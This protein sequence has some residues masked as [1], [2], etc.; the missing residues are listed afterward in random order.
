M[1]RLN[2][3]LKELNVGINM[4]AEFLQK[5][6]KPLEDASINAKITDEQYDMLLKEFGSDKQKKQE[7]SLDIQ[8]RK[9]KEQAE[10][11]VRKAKEL[12]ELLRREAELRKQKEQQEVFRLESG[13]KSEVKVL[14]KH[15]ETEEMSQAPKCKP[16]KNKTMLEETEDGVY[17]VVTPEAGLNFKK[18]GSIDIN[19][20][21]PSTR[22]QKKTKED[23]RKDSDDKKYI[24]D[25]KPTV[26]RN[27]SSSIK[28]TNISSL[29][30]FDWEQFEA[31]ASDA[32]ENSSSAVS[33]QKHDIVIATVTALNRNEIAVNFGY[34]SDAIIP[35]SE[36]RYNPNLKVGDQID[37]YIEEIANNRGQLLVS[38]RKAR[39]SKAWDKI[40]EAYRNNETIKVYVK[41]ITKGGMI[42][43]ALGIDA[44]MP[45]SQIDI[46]KVFNYDSYIGKTLD[47]KVIKINIENGN[48]VVSHKEIVAEN[49]QK[50]ST[51]KTLLKDIWQKHTEVQEQ[52]LR[53]R[54]EPISIIPSFSTIINEKLHVRIDTSDNTDYL[55]SMIIKSLEISD[56]DCHFDDGYVFAPY[57]NWN[58]LDER[59][60]SRISTQANKEYVSFS[61]CPVIDGKITDIK[62]QFTGV[63]ELLD[64]LEIEYDFD[65]KR[66]LQISINELQRLRNN[67][68][69]QN[70]QVSLPDEASAIIQTYPSILYYLERECPNHKFK[71]VEVFKDSSST[72]GGVIINKQ[73]IVEGGYFNEETLKKL[74]ELFEIRMCKIE[75]EFKIKDSAKGQY[76]WK[77]NRSGLPILEEGTILFRKNVKLSVSDVFDEDKIEV[78]EE[79]LED[80]TDIHFEYTLDCQ[81]VNRIFGKGNYEVIQRFFYKYKENR[82]WATTE[83]L[84]R[85]NDQIHTELKG[86]V[87]IEKNGSSIGIDFNW[88]EKSLPEIL[89]QLSS[90]Y[91]F[92]D[93][94]LFKKGHK[95]NFDIKYKKAELTNL[96]EELHDSFDKLNVELVKKDTELLFY[97]EFDTLEELIAFR[98]QLQ[99]K[100][101]TFDA[102][103][104][105]CVVNDTPAGY[106]KLLYYYDKKSRDEE[107]VDSIRE[108]KGA[109]FSIGDLSIGRLIR[110]SNYPEIVI[111][112]SGDNYEVTKQLIE[113]SEVSSIT[114]DLS[115]DLEKLARLKESL[116]RIVQG[117]DVENASLGDF[118]FDASKAG[119]I[120]DY[121]ESIKLE[122]QEISKHILNKKIDKN[123]PQ[124]IAIAKALLAPDL[125]LIQGPP[126]TGKSTAIAELI[127]QHT[128]ENPDKRILLTSETNLAVDNA[129]DRVVNQ[130]HNLIK[131]IRIG[132]ESRLETEGLQFSYSAMY[133]WA[134]G[135]DWNIKKKNVLID[136]DEDD[137][138]YTDMDS[139]YEAPE[140]L[141]LLNWMENV[142]RRLDSERM[143]SEAQELWI[144]LLEN[145]TPELKNLFF[146]N[147]I[148]NCNVIGATCSS[149]GQKNIIMTESIEN[150]GKRNR[151]VPT[152]FYRIYRQIFSDKEG[153]FNP[154]IYFDMVI[155]DESSKATPAELS[156]PLIYGKKNVIIGDHKQLP[157]MLSRESFINSFDYLIKREKNDD[158]RQK[159]KELKSY[160]LKNFKTLE[161]S[162]F[163]RLFTQIDDNLKGVFNYQFRMHPAIN[164]V[165][166][167]FYKDEG[168]L[169]CGLIT[170]I[171]LGVDD[172][173]YL[174]NGSSRYHGITAGP[175]D[176][177][178][179]VLWIDSSSPEM[180]DGTSR[181]NY[182]E[183]AI[184]KKLLTELNESESFHKY[185]DSWESVED[186]QIGLI[187]FYGKQLR[188]LKDMTREFDNT[189]IPVRVSTVDRFQG[190]ERNII[191]VSMVRSHCIQNEKNQNPNFERYP[192]DGFPKQEDLGFAQSPNRLNVAL[193]RAK[194]LLIIVGNSKLFR[195]KDIYENVY[196]TIADKYNKYG[197]IITASEYGL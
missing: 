185:I 51:D 129:I 145:P 192:E 172:P 17:H 197:K 48:V 159:M 61:Y 113:E 70:L 134:K 89:T 160:V 35:A 130:Y 39:L 34:K 117:R 11:A 191:I 73:L 184:I 108:L 92:I 72:L 9:E 104:Y 19:E 118:I 120:K 119:G 90:E 100:L 26:S 85:F 46:V 68:D 102:T 128:R 96:M 186:K 196:Q 8:K 99:N 77:K 20:I 24:P 107:R 155:Q 135:E 55:K 69:F 152:K 114:P 91:G 167:Q 151:F 29:D 41:C 10:R 147:Y 64:K 3:A 154:K 110:I 66:R 125:A 74:E 148:K 67:E 37:V 23:R 95:C 15:D 4:V 63:K 111:D 44:F 109:D 83:E 22:P 162:H 98:P 194:R 164:D 169:E 168:G 144:N 103:R 133:R 81:I 149:I 18:V 189:Q 122:E 97:R 157:P 60:K 58:N 71:N 163:E 170:P 146:D 28:T 115:G 30:D 79:I 82:S 49:L 56:Q 87:G 38:H 131:P 171:D 93:F 62:A 137:D 123:Q 47:V 181:V 132:D 161:I 136:E 142:G 165:I 76:D 80:T 94:G 59:E 42:V 86:K 193:S 187:S 65:K 21:N 174:N 40:N 84:D 124:K 183:V 75:Y 175:I 176:P 52:I 156:L 16:S 53:Q 116:N 2:K 12:Q 138:V 177:E 57:K 88:K 126:G 105:K 173:D 6:G 78:V 121:E 190:M 33:L 182:G 45:G 13:R 36:L 141:I 179:H 139:I 195:T 14:G 1:P 31:S 140:K 166:K 50:R 5:K 150:T 112:I 143:P 43:D 54:T 178:T 7:T 153:V 25:Q 32:A 106:V 180:L 158:E 101:S 188:L 27:N 127:W